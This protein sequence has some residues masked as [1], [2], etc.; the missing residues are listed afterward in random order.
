[1]V[2]GLSQVPILE[3]LMQFNKKLARFG[4]LNKN[5]LFLANNL[6]YKKAQQGVG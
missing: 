1:M 4:I 6:F 3:F 5:I 2:T